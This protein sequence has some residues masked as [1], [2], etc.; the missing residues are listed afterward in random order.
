MI[1]LF[2]PYCIIILNSTGKKSTKSKSA[3]K[4]K[5]S[6]TKY[7]KKSAS[8]KQNATTRKSPSPLSD[9]KKA[10]KERREMVQVGSGKIHASLLTEA[11][12]LQFVPTMTWI[13]LV[14]Y[15]RA[16]G[17]AFDC[18]K[19]DR[20]DLS[21]TDRV[22]KNITN[23][24]TGLPC[25]LFHLSIRASLFHLNVK[26]HYSHHRSSSYPDTKSVTDR[27][28]WMK[29]RNATAPSGACAARMGANTELGGSAFV[30][31]LQLDQT[32]LPFR[33]LPLEDGTT[34]VAAIMPS[35][36][37]GHCSSLALMNAA[38]ME[39][40]TRWKKK[41]ESKKMN[42]NIAAATHL[43]NILISWGLKMH[44]KT[45]SSNVPGWEHTVRLYTLPTSVIGSGQATVHG[46]IRDGA[47]A[48]RKKLP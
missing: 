1:F 13:Q 41:V 34:T 23:Y 20:F 9:A 25:K 4:K 18:P 12:A 11:Q 43:H 16:N 36:E 39:L 24:L 46:S 26:T 47:K 22:R 48:M 28:L 32:T 21:A 3:P 15:A 33:M 17:L 2:L 44:P 38:K 6:S 37:D 30:R 14:A 19:E 35:D 5:P 45:S 42:M 29:K 27:S 40:I 7:T 8:S 10:A 31:F